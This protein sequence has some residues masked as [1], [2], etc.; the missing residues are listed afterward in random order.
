VAAQALPASSATVRVVQGLV[1]ADGAFAQQL[2]WVGD[3]DLT[4]FA[5]VAIAA[6]CCSQMGRASRA[7]TVKAL[8]C[9]A[10]FTAQ[11]TT[12]KH[13]F[14]LWRTTDACMM[15][16]FIFDHAMILQHAGA[17]I[18]IRNVSHRHGT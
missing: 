10:L 1:Q 12:S 4:F 14:G 18:R 17:A 2:H 16:L 6:V 8:Q 3:Y 9:L 15:S 13:V 5:K 11:P 7:R